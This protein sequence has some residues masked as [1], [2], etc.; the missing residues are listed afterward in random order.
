MKNSAL[1]SNTVSNS[2][3]GG[4]T[5][6]TTNDR[7]IR[8][9]NE[10]RRELRCNECKRL[11]C[12]GNCAPGHE[13]RQYKRCVPPTIIVPT[14]TRDQNR[15][16]LSLRTQRSTSDIR[17]CS[18]QQITRETK[19]KFESTNINPLVVVPLDVNESQAKRSSKKVT[20]RYVSTKTVRPP[21][22]ET[23][24]L[25]SSPKVSS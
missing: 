23:I 9:I 19:F 7:D 20:N 11:A 21:R 13:Y 1:D 18:T 5:T 15:N 17:P 25:I 4:T 8:D 12:L 24:A 2:H 14:G 3:G 16:K 6:K 10:L 22:R